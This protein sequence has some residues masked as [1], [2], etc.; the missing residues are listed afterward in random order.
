M[1]EFLQHTWDQLSEPLFQGIS[2]LVG[3]TYAHLLTWIG[4]FLGILIIGRMLNEKRNPSNIFAWAFA[5][6]LF[7]WIGVP[8]YF[9]FGGRKSRG[10][11]ER[12][13]KV[14]E[15]SRYLAG[16]ENVP[17]DQLKKFRRTTGNSCVLLPDAPSTFNAILRG[18][19]ES[20]ECIHIMTYILSRD[21]AGVAVVEALT[22]RAREGVKVRLLLD[23]FGFFGN[24]GEWIEELKRS[25]GE[26]SRFMPLVP[27]HTHS[28]A[29]LRNHR[30]LAIFD[31]RIAITGGQNIDLRF[32]GPEDTP[33]TF[34][35]FSI[36]VEGPVL[37]HM[38][39][40]FLNDWI[41]ASEQ[42]PE[43][44]RELFQLE[45]PSV[46]D[47]NLEVIESGP[48]VPTDALYERILGIIQECR[49]SLTI[50]TP[51]FVPDEVLFRSLIV[52]AHSGRRVRLIIPRHSNQKLVD[53]ARF[54]YLR[55][56]EDAG[57][58]VLFYLPGM[59]HAKLILVDDR[60]ALSGSANFDMRS[61]FVNFEMGIVHDHP[62][63]FASF[64]DWVAEIEKECRPMSETEAPRGKGRRWVEDFAHLVGPLL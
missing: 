49:E 23:A 39:F 20:Q 25:G 14:M 42:K 55:Q 62:E 33:E 24:G 2:I 12:K 31:H 43:Q 5:V 58:E 59:I 50:V 45:F 41:F 21:K 35:D 7:P 56:L 34:R 60:I 40:L 52:K 6:L 9:F 10:L 17:G 27:L 29:N 46:G 37:R 4:F 38:N 32:M 54:H 3:F 64:R 61:F 8:M 22:R 16:E 11:V 36:R 15:G 18:I 48:E 1:I 57:V 44:F 30:K 63:D 13:R 26:V 28:S 47:K 19:E 51:Y 53:V